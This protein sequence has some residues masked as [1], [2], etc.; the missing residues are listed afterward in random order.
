M[1]CVDVR[2][3]QEHERNKNLFYIKYILIWD[4][5][6]SKMIKLTDRNTYVHMPKWIYTRLFIGVAYVHTRPICTAFLPGSTFDKHS[7]NEANFFFVCSVDVLRVVMVFKLIGA[8]YDFDQRLYIIFR[9]WPENVLID[10]IRNLSD[11]YTDCVAEPTKE[12]FRA[13]HARTH[14][15]SISWWTHVFLIFIYIECFKWFV[16]ACRT[17]SAVLQTWVWR[18]SREWTRKKQPLHQIGVNFT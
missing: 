8:I 13:K 18:E 10:D 1:H 11:T 9:K 12:S 17:K 15:G 7:E 14:I 4:E 5:A 6:I 3:H 16:R 2:L